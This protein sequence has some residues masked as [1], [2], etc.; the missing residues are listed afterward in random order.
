M[1][2]KMKKSLWLAWI[3][4][5]TFILFAQMALANKTVYVH[6]LCQVNMR[7]GP[8]TNYRVTATLLSGFAV[9]VLGQ[10]SDWSKV[11]F[12][13][14]DDQA[15]EG[16]ILN[17]FLADQ[18]P[19]AAQAKSMTSSL[20]EQLACA[21]E[22]KDQLSQ[23]ESELTLQLQSASDKLK[24]LEAEYQ[25]LQAGATDYLKLK[26]EYESA[27]IALVK[28]QDDVDTMARQID[29]L[30]LSQKIRWFIAGAVVLICG[31][32]IGVVMGR[33]QRKRRTNFR[34]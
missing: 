7:S 29:N 15:I 11:R 18:P 14:E 13:K 2:G 26:E 28:A 32:V 5:S 16:W 33:Y 22:E 8:G 25:S 27:K 6:D 1:D 23:S 10:Q 9:E 3:V 24:K 17:R 31:W 4:F 30:K 20:K 21:V 19:W 34:V 12:M